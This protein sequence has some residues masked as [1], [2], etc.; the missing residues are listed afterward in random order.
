M[1]ITPS[2]S[3]DWG[4]T[5][6]SSFLSGCIHHWLLAT[7]NLDVVN[8]N[9]QIRPHNLASPPLAKLQ[10][11]SCA[12]QSA[13]LSSEGRRLTKPA[14][15]N[16]SNNNNNSR[17]YSI[18]P[19]HIVFHR[20]SSALCVGGRIAWERRAWRST[21]CGR[22]EAIPCLFSILLLATRGNLHLRFRW[23]CNSRRA[24]LCGCGGQGECI[25]LRP[26]MKNF[27]AVCFI[28]FF[29]F[30]QSRLAAAFLV[31]AASQAFSP[32][33]PL[34]SSCSCNWCFHSFFE[35]LCLLAFSWDH[36]KESS[37]WSLCVKAEAEG[38]D[39]LAYVCIC[40][41]RTQWLLGGGIQRH[42]TS[43]NSAGRSCGK[44]A[45]ARQC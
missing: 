26:V 45:W 11:A 22:E 39:V 17:F 32:G 34:A 25:I 8:T 42:A 38:M 1:K 4:G 36:C 28:A 6:Q 12:S 29:L 2:A 31:S 43:H 16:S 19:S 35:Q 10:A 9:S 5:W 41:R 18:T 24:T 14:P 23:S 30:L 37:R 3:R 44:V 33:Q 27:L 15:A 40:C 21:V 20:S 13:T 7:R